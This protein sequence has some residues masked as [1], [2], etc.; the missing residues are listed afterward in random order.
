MRQTKAGMKRSMGSGIAVVTLVMVAISAGVPASTARRELAPPVER[1]A[2]IEDGE[3]VTIVADGGVLGRFRGWHGALAWSPDGTRLRD[4][5]R[6]A[7]T[8][9]A[10]T[11]PLWDGQ[12]E[13]QS[14]QWSPDGLTLLGATE[15]AVYEL[16]WD[17]TSSRHVADVRPVVVDGE[18]Q[19]PDFVSLFRAPAGP[20]AAVERSYQPGESIAGGDVDLLDV[21][22]GRWQ[23]MPGFASWAPDGASFAF[24][25]GDGSLH[26]AEVTAPQQPLEVATRASRPL[27]WSPSS[28]KLVYQR[29]ETQ[30]SEDEPRPLMVVDVTADSSP[31]ELGSFDGVGRVEWSPDGSRLAVS[32][33]ERTAERVSDGVDR[34]IENREVGIV[35]VASGQLTEITD[36]ADCHEGGL[37]WLR[38]GSSLV[39]DSTD[40]GEG[41][42]SCGQDGVFRHDLER[43]QTILLRAGAGLS[44]GP[45]PVAF[46]PSSRVMGARRIGTAVAASRRSFEAASTVML[47]RADAYPD[48][49]AGAPLAGKEQAPV[50]LTH[51]DGL[52]TAVGAEIDRLG[53]QRAVILGQRDVV[54]EQV[55]E[56]LRRRGLEVER[57]GGS[58]RFATA[59][60][61]AR[62]VAGE[63][64]QEVYLTEGADADPARGWP[65]AAA[66]SALAAHRGVPVL[67]TVTD[68]LPEVTRQALQGVQRVTIVGGPPAVSTDVQ[69]AIEAMGIEVDRLAGDGRYATSAAVANASISAGMDPSRLWAVT[70]GGWPDALTLGPAAAHAGGVLL[71]VPPHGIP[72]SLATADWLRGHADAVVD[73][74]IGGGISAISP[75]TVHDLLTDLGKA[76]E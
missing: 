71:L 1:I 11:F 36:T 59:A 48:A 37:Q 72:D 35:D 68:R 3:L 6:V 38:D 19:D 65:D 42:R 43:G 41:D 15:D 33:V 13:L 29:A 50:L 73:V 28:Q 4:R 20:F 47:A 62:R 76:P 31:R 24:L 51:R 32:Y 60:M 69:R 45:A 39:Y 18:E 54:S 2:V 14:T 46:G 44:V 26:V 10:R 17:G 22:T 67:L 5:D 27:A 56:Q 8:F 30:Q 49:L 25:D 70:G 57:I 12:N 75:Q 16:A 64:P 58:D 21:A 7:D 63:T 61:L 74:A 23:D 53:A 9:G 55:A 34:V 40:P 66:V 52:P